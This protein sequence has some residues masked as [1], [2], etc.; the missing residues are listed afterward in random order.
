[1][2]ADCTIDQAMEKMVDDDDDLKEKQMRLLLLVEEHKKWLVGVPSVATH[3]PRPH[4]H[5]PRH[6]ILSP[7]SSSS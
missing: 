6:Q 3:R 7:S 4:H 2:I 1:M 5:R